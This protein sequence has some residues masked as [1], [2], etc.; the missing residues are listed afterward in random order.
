MKIENRKC[1]RCKHLDDQE[2]YSLPWCT[3]GATAYVNKPCNKFEMEKQDEHP[4][5]D[6]ACIKNEASK[7][8]KDKETA[9]H[10]L[11]DA[12]IFN[13]KDELTDIYK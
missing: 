8:V 7:I 5:L 10:L 6:D 4:C 2:G 11:K 13:D 3:L 12:G 9:L 1:E